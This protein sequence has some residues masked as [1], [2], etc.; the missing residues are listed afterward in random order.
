MF[1]VVCVCGSPG[2]VGIGKPGASPGAAPPRPRPR[3]GLQR[4]RGGVSPPPP[5][6]EKRNN[7]AI[8]TPPMWQ[9]LLEPRW[10]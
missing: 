9:A 4:G 6:Q 8:Q 5:T 1:D 10:R 7:L 2:A 3:D